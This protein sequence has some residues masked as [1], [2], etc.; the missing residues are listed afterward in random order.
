MT[1]DDSI[2]RK[3]T[4]RFGPSAVAWLDALPALVESLCARWDLTVE[5]AVAVGGT[6]R[7]YRCR[8]E[9]GSRAFLK[10]T[11]DREV[12]A[13]ELIALRAWRRSPHMVDVLA[14]DLDAGALLLPAIDP[15]T[16]IE[17]EP[18]LIPF[19]VLRSLREDVDVPATGL[20]HLSERVKFM[21]ELTIRRAPELE[22][23]TG[24]GIELT[25]GGPQGLVHGDL[26]ARNVLRGPHGL[27]AIDP[28]PT[29]GDVTFDLVDWVLT[30][31][32]DTLAEL[33]RRITR[34]TSDLSE[35]DGDRVLVWC[36]A[37]AVVI[38]ATLPPGAQR[39]FLLGLAGR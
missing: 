37:L 38:A 17:D 15:G 36:S 23:L 1:V 29:I 13:T 31:T 25:Y 16:M 10:L 26:H 28:R 24:K 2:R 32:V 9:D 30:P 3:F 4:V 7:V 33:E 20:P 21:A 5:Q 11:P 14:D 19:E 6:S 8:R 35:V 18:D 12:A 22:S 39:D 34:L 27:V